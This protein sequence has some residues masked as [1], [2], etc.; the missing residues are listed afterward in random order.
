MAIVA[1]T[2]PGPSDGANHVRVASNRG[3]IPAVSV[4]ADRDYERRMLQL[5][6]AL[7]VCASPQPC[8]WGSVRAGSLSPE[9]RTVVYRNRDYRPGQAVVNNIPPG[10]KIFI[11][12]T[13][14]CGVPAR[15]RS[16]CQVRPTKGS[17]LTDRSRIRALGRSPS[18]TSASPLGLGRSPHHTVQ[19]GLA[20]AR[21]AAAYSSFSLSIFVPLI[22]LIIARLPA[23]SSSA[24][25][26]SCASA[27]ASS[28]SWSRRCR[29]P[30]RGPQGAA[31][32]AQLPG[33]TP[34]VLKSEPCLLQSSRPARAGR[35][36]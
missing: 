5:G 15:G 19:A 4:P 28:S 18:A 20:T 6:K 29:H 7:E 32:V 3:A 14:A 31:A 24:P 34:K 26:R 33:P 16:C 9:V 12:S 2:C 35:S 25:R 10:R 11:I 1:P 27:E 22:S 17:D 13:R 23:C 21:C 8:G 30:R 36:A